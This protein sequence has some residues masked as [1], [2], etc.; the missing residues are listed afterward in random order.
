[1]IKANP[2][3]LDLSV[4]FFGIL[5]YI[6]HVI[7]SFLAQEELPDFYEENLEQI[8]VVLSFVLE[9]DFSG[10]PKVPIEIVKCRAKVVRVVH[11]YQFKFSEFF[12]KYQ[13]YFFGK[14]WDMV[15]HG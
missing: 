5:N 6:L 4:M 8:A 14:I 15:L 7:E 12:S 9:S 13:S 10:L 11:I 1:M 3:N 2:G